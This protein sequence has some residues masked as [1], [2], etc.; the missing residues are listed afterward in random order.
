MTAIEK[1]PAGAIREASES[2]NLISFGGNQNGFDISDY[3]ENQ[4]KTQAECALC[5]PQISVNRKPAANLCGN[6][7]T[8]QMRLEAELLGHLSKPRK[9]IR[10]H[11]CAACQKSVTP[12][13]FSRDWGICKSC[14]ADI[15]SKSKL[16]RSNFVER[17]VNNFRKIVLQNITVKEKTKKIFF[18]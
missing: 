17:A 5:N 12:A 4:T 11:R 14:V 1:A 16:A 10:L 7:A 13:R 6:C 8:A 9:I 18:A 2:N 3:A 15:V